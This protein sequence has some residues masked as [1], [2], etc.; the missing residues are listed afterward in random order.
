MKG[1]YSAI[2]FLTVLPAGRSGTFDPCG[3]VRAFPLAGLLVGFLLALFDAVVSSLWPAPAAALLDVLFL[4]VITAA[5]HID[6]LGDAA[7]GMYGH[8]TR[9][10]ALEIMKDSRVGIMGLVAVVSA[11]GVKWAG[12]SG[13]DA[14][15]FLLLTII[16][17][18]ARGAMLFGF[19]FLP[20]GRPGGGTGHAFFERPLTPADFRWLLLPLLLSLFAGPMMALRLNLIYGLFILLI[21]YYYHRRMGCITG[22]M[23]GAMCEAIEAGLFLMVAAGG[24]I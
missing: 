11:L 9:E 10:R 23:L 21:L 13:L 4:L 20:Y 3:M 6:G 1:L 22:D 5:F 12:I 16:P 2:R 15:R 7:D 8:H 24:G 17:A 19:R 18:Y 14:D